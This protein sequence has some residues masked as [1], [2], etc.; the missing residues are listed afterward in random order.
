MK[1]YIVDLSRKEC[2]IATKMLIAVV[3]NKIIFN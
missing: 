3:Q 2:K 1:I